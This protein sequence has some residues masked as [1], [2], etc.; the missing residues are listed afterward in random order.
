MIQY[1]YAVNTL[2]L[3]RAIAQAGVGADEAKI[4]ELY[5]SY[6][7]LVDDEATGEEAPKKKG[8]K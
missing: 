1:P 7:G 3:S 2:K 4:K 8:K 5:I 6:G